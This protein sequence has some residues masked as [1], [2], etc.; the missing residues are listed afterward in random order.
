MTGKY[1][2]TKSYY[3]QWNITPT[4]VNKFSINPCE[5]HKTIPNSFEGKS[6][7]VDWVS[8]AQK[9]LL[10]AISSR[11]QIFIKHPEAAV[12]GVLRKICSENMQQIYRRTP[13]PKCNFNKVVLELYWNCT[14]AWVFSCKFAAYFQNTFS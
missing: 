4:L 12:R 2:H 13:M 5:P 6:K 11:M 10:Y 3:Q 8:A 7:F 14:S 1:Q 9:S